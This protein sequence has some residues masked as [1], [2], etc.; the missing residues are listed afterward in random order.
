[1]A[2]ATASAVGVT[3]VGVAACAPAKRAGSTG[4]AAAAGRAG[5]AQLSP[6]ESAKRSAARAAVDEFVR[7]G[8]AVGVGSGSTIVYAIERLGERVRE[9]GLDI[10]CVP[11]S[12]QSEQ[13]CD[14]QG[15]RLSEL[16]RTPVLDIAI[17]GADEVDGA[18]N[19]IKGGGGCQAREKCVAAAAKKFVI[20]ADHRKQSTALGTQWRKGVPVEVLPFAWAAVK[21]RLEAMDATVELRMATKKAGPVV[22]DTGNLILDVDFGRIDD[23]AALEAAITLVPGVTE[24]GL[25]VRM[26]SRAY[27]GQADGSVEVWQ[28]RG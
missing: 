20:V 26:A 11:T 27:F 3:G 10:V 8:M 13:L 28:P 22:T 1:M 16:T 9:E 18:L 5:A 7:D 6:L 25:F 2:I 21:R 24:A 12:F 17:D 23:P 15:L 4:R 19:A 14:E